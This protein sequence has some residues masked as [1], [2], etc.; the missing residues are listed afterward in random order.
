MA[1]N[2]TDF[3]NGISDAS[4]YLSAQ[5]SVNAQLTGSTADI[6]R[7]IVSAELDSTLKEIIC[8]LLAGRGLK[9]PNTQICV[10]LNLQELLALPN[11]QA[12]L[13]TAL[14]SLA[15]ALNS[16]LDHTKIE[17]VL[18]RINNILAEV[19]NIANMINFCSSPVD[20][21]A[22]PNIL[23]TSM[24]SFLGVGVDL[25]AQIGSMDPGQIGGCLI[26]GQFNCAA[27]NGGILGSICDNIADVTAGTAD[28]NF[29][30]SIVAESAIIVT[31]ITDLINSE[32]GVSGNYDQ[33]GSDLAEDTREVNEGIGALHNAADA[34]IQGNTRIASQLKALYD[35]LGSYQVVGSDGTVYNNIFE[36]F[37]DP[38]LLRVLRRASDPS[39]EIAERQPVY[40][41]CGEIVGYTKAITQSTQETSVGTVPA[42]ITQPGFNAG[43]LI[44]DPISEAEGEVDA[45]GAVTNVITN[46][47]N[48]TGGT[49]VLFADSEAAQLALNTTLG[50][51]VFRTDTDITYVDNG[52]TADTIADYNVIGI[53]ELGPFL[54]NV[55]NSTG[56][57]FLVRTTDAP[58]YRSIVGTSNQ[59]TVANGTGATGNPTVAITANPIIP[60]TNSLRLPIGTTGQRIDGSGNIR[61]NT[62]TSLFEGYNGSSWD[63]FTTGTGTVT[64]GANVG[65]G[66]YEVYKQN[67]NNT[68]EFRTL[69]VSGAI[70]MNT[71]TAVITVG[72]AITGSSLGGDTAVFSSRVT[73]DLQFRGITAGDN[74]LLV[75]NAN[76]IVITADLSDYNGT[77]AT[78]TA[79]L[80]EVLFNGT[81]PT[82]ASGKAWFFEVVAT[83]KRTNGV[84]VT[85]IKIE[86]VIDNTAGT[87]T[88]AGTTGN[89]TIFN[90][91]AGTTNYDLTLDILV[92]EF[93]VQVNGDTGHNVNWSVRYKFQEV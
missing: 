61:F 88:I 90:S 74:I 39:P 76:D 30:N 60:G 56:D 45:T 92:N 2:F 37:V 34:G 65:G 75:Q 59:I 71:A 11:L 46:V 89:K 58:S 31:A 33:G 24:Q 10:S 48:V 9:L 19:S 17:S 50:D 23:E 78:T 26:D 54:E 32:T 15:D 80:I 55:D 16:F 22:I 84:G 43:G 1:N 41:Y 42:V 85:A 49:G 3:P 63:F 68:L 8:S 28:V 91:T 44:T 47:T 83:A 81:R 67:N 93:R 5:S 29:V 12:E 20:P 64:D 77:T 13:F 27:F 7:F 18:G 38:D 21:I 62:T 69:A 6:S 40:N 4:T 66:G 73:N 72:E 86:G 53:G 35:N 57:G 36:T 25:I 87:V 52:G 79:A 82:P 14:T 51:I 70:T